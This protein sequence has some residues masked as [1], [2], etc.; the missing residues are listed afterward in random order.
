LIPQDNSWGFLFG[1]II[2]RYWSNTMNPQRA[3]E[4]LDELDIEYKDV[5]RGTFLYVVMKDDTHIPFSKLLREHKR[6]KEAEVSD[7][8]FS[9]TP[10]EVEEAKPITEDAYRVDSQAE[11]EKIVK[12]P[13][14]KNK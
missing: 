5:K 2:N 6:N 14:K 1:D 8:L 3:K 12:K 9:P 11:T 13:R 10:I 4:I 7:I